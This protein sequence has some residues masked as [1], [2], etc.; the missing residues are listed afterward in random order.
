MSVKI[1]IGT[2]WGDEGKGKIVDLLSETA[3]VVARY[4][5]GANAGHTVEIG[6]RRFILHL[7][8]AG[9]LRP[10]TV[11]V[12]GNGVV[13]DPAAL[14]HEID[15]VR[16]E[17]IEI[18][19]RLKISHN[20]HLIMPY[21][22]KL[23]SLR[24]RGANKIG[25]T[26]RGIGPAYIDK[27]QRVGIR[28]VDLLNRDY[29]E[30]RIRM[31]LTEKNQ[32]LARIYRSEELDVESIITEYQE[33]DRLI[34]PYVTDTSL[35]I[36]TAISEGKRILL[37]GAQGTLLDLDHGTYPYVTSSNPISGGACV[38]LGIPPTCIDEIV[39]V[40]KAYFT[41]V[42]EGP[43][44]TEETGGIGEELREHGDE[45]GATTG[46]PRRCGWFD[47]FAMRYST[48]INGCT[49]LALTKLDVLGAFDTIPVCIGYKLEGRLLKSFPTAARILEQV[50]PVYQTHPGWKSDISQITRWE[51]LPVEARQYVRTI[52]E[53][54]Q[55]PVSLLSVGPKRRQTIIVPEE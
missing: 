34:D 55:V 32:I 15:M 36:N 23:D 50:E 48:L 20:A 10:N 35:F 9:I 43:F 2:Q 42:G 40:S 5:G 33:F 24:E 22:K 8:P 39:G 16:K 11:C 45:F 4:Q 37:E 1:V 44:P 30:Q 47:A 12:I 51:D 18:E 3:D 52:S 31:N 53:M 13:V 19:G 7:L 28:I 21:H 26:G 6:D 29:L 54:V 25:T 14:L 41:R 49:S 38:G 27:A 46:R 17:G